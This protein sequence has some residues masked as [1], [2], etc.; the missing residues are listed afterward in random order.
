MNRLVRAELFKLRTTN[1]WWLFALASILATAVMLVVDG[2]SAHSLLKPLAQYLVVESHGHAT[3]LPPEFLARLTDE[4][5]L[6]H[7][8]ATQAVVLYTSGQLPGVLLVC[9]LGVV[10]VTSEYHH[11]TATTTFLLTPRRTSVI[12]A[13]LVSA[14]LLAGLAWLASTVLSVVAGAI[15]LH[16]EGYGSQLAHGAVVR[17]LLLNL[18]AYLL[19]AVFGVGVGALV[20]HQLAATVGVTVLYLV[21]ASAASSIFD[22]L[23]TYVL[24]RD[25]VLTAQV[26]VPTVASAVMISPTKTFDQSPAPWV[27]A[28]V[29]LAYGLVLGG[30]GVATLRRRDIA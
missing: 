11:Q 27:G 4:W 14:V 19:W 17:A 24:Q 20:R 9:L 21:G 10:L 5:T 30:L 25:W 28:V 26:V 13:K 12:T 7:P 29:L 15:F 18:A 6:G 8:A 23:N 3:N 2:V 1:A 16:V 22:L